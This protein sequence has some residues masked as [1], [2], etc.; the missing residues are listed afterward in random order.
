MRQ[1]VKGL[2]IASIGVLAL[3]VP[4]SAVTFTQIGSNDIVD[5]AFSPVFTL[6]DLTFVASVASVDDDL[7]MTF[8]GGGGNVIDSTTG[9]SAG[10]LLI[11]VPFANETTF[12]FAGGSF[13]TQDGTAPHFTT[14]FFSSTF[15]VWFTTHT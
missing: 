8:T 6:S 11:P 13:Y 5:S 9:T 14:S 10:F 1:A 12:H 4:A 2:F 3:A 15:D 7:T